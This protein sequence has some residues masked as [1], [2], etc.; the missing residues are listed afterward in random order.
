[1]RVV[2]LS[3]QIYTSPS[4]K[5]K[6]I[7]GISLIVILLALIAG[8]VIYSLN[9]RYKP[10]EHDVRAQKGLPKV[11]ENYLFGRIE[12]DYGYRFF[13]A[14]NLFRQ[15]DG[16]VNIYFTNPAGSEVDLM[17][18]IYDDSSGELLFRSGLL[19]PAEYV[20]NLPPLGKYEN[21]YRDILVKVY[22]LEK[23]DHTSA[24]TTE[25]R[26]ALQPW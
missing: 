1:M 9:V 19:Y 6:H 25:L 20:D 21:E 15:E 14:G 13:M 22:A 5:K 16:S 8:A 3:R 18:E 2:A 7:L 10:P 12:S 26:L 23:D 11:D 24:G 4:A 17:A